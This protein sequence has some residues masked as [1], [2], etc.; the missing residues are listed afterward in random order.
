VSANWLALLA[1][2]LIGTGIVSPALAERSKLGV[3]LVLAALL[4]G[5]LVPLVAFWTWRGWLVNL[6]LVDLAGAAPIH[7]TPA[8]CAATAVLLVGPR[9]GKYNRDGSS[10]MIPGHSVPLIL[11]STMLT[12]AGWIP[13]VVGRATAGQAAVVGANVMISAAAAGL[14]SLIAARIRFG[15]ADVLLTCI[16]VMGG[17]VSITAAA[18]VVGTP[19]AF[20]IGAVAGLLIPF[21]AVQLDLT[22]KLDDPAGVIAIHGVG[23]LWA[24]VAAAALPDH[25]IIE[26]LRL[27]GIHALGIVVIS[28]TVIALCGSVLLLLRA[29]TGL[30]SK[31]ADEYD[32]L[33]LAEHD[34][35][36]HPDFQQTMI[37]SYHLREA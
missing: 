26:R 25:S 10:N 21:M 11:T 24:L 20:V 2:T 22:L 13:Y 32:G 8:L 37:K 12:V 1:V 18:G 33:D 30:R 19:G 3:T 14:S 31:E 16:G 35:N 4:G 7:L 6:G 27:L 17:L 5:V 29:V 28:V 34:I 36:A 23:G 9:D 15:K